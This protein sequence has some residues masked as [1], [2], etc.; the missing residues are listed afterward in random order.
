[1]VSPGARAIKARSCRRRAQ[2]AAP[3]TC[4]LAVAVTHLRNVLM[5]A[6]LMASSTSPGCT[7][8][9]AAAARL[10]DDRP[11]S[12]RRAT[13]AVQR[14]AAVM[15]PVGPCPRRHRCAPVLIALSLASPLSW[16]SAPAVCSL[17]PTGNL[18]C[19]PGCALARLQTGRQ[20]T[21]GRPSTWRITC[22]PLQV[23]PFSARLF[24]LTLATSAPSGLSRL[25]DLGKRLVHLLHRHA[26]LRVAHLAGGND[27]VP[28]LAASL[29]GMG[30]RHP[31]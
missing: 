15:R 4:P 2:S 7:P 20:A 11:S 23:G 28:I 27:L 19:W 21:D 16:R 5:G 1:M 3:P 10:L 14:S 8:A 26:Q 18:A 12:G 17:A 13:P 31:W 6:P 24:L 22:P 25:N 29:M 30:E 9:A